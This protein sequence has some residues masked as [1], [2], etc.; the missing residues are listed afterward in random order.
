MEAPE[1]RV[2]LERRVRPEHEVKEDSKAKLA[3]REFRDHPVSV[4]TPDP[5]GRTELEA[6]QGRRALKDIKDPPDSW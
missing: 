3:N 4:E 2:P 5:R 6:P 1:S